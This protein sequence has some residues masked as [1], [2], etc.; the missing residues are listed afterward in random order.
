MIV[1]EILIN[2]PKANERYCSLAFFLNKSKRRSLLLN[3]ERKD[4]I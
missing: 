2:K 1:C 3:L 4:G